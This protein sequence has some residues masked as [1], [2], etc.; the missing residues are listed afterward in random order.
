MNKRRV[1]WGALF[2][3]VPPSFAAV[4]SA[5][6]FLSDSTPLE[7]K[8]YWYCWCIALVFVTGLYIVSR[9]HVIFPKKKEDEQWLL[10]E[11]S[12]ERE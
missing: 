10:Q 4:V 9:W 11:K 3:V 6:L 8:D 2:L 1:D 12:K 5:C 7:D